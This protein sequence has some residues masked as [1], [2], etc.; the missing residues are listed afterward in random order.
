MTRTTV[1]LVVFSGFLI[2]EISAGTW[3]T[4]RQ[5][6]RWGSTRNGGLLDGQPHNNVAEHFKDYFFFLP[7][8][9]PFLDAFGGSANGS[10]RSTS[11][12]PAIHRPHTL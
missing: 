2:L 8:P 5:T 12:A 6:D 9:F 11:N 1:S 3:H 4:D 7:A 10:G